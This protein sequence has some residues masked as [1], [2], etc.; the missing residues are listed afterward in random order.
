MSRR[1]LFFGI[2]VVVITIVNALWPEAPSPLT[3]SSFGKSGSGHA[4]LYD[5]LSE[6]GLARGRS[7]EASR[8]LADSGTLWWIDPEGVCDGRIARSG[9]ANVLDA[10]DVAWPGGEWIRAGGTAVVFLQAADLG[11]PVLPPQEELVEC[12]AIAGIAL[13]VVTRLAATA[14]VADADESFAVVEGPLVE[15]PRALPSS[16]VHAFG[17]AYDWAVGARIAPPGGDLLPFVLMRSLGEGTLVVV[18]DSGFTHNAALDRGDSAPLA[19]DLV[20][21][22]GR[23]RFDEREHGL[24]PA[25]SAFRYLAGSAARPVY[26]GLA[27]LGLLYL[28]RGNALP[29]RSV[30]EDDPA[31]PTLETYVRSMAA[32][33][34]RTGDYGRVLERYR[35]LTASRL[36][37]HFGLPQDVSPRALAERIEI[38]RRLSSDSAEHDGSASRL[39]AGLAQLTGQGGATSPAQVEAAAQELDAL[40]TEVTR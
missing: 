10:A 21:A 33:Y 20:E 34:A 14:G 35:E 38:D 29:A 27:L 3:N 5:L 31:A 17:R 24:L 23:P 16:A 2:G 26:A 11:G 32:L 6:S 13:P 9:E 36:K 15:S 4:A 18:A 40:V 39:R 37:R 25:T 7:F 28:W 30:P 12:D 1:L 8:R 19:I 22:F